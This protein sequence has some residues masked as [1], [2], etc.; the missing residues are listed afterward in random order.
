MATV[1]VTSSPTTLDTG[2]ATTRLI[3]DNRGP[4]PVTLSNGTTV[5]VFQ[6]RQVAITAGTPLTATA[7]V[8]TVV[9]VDGQPA[10]ALDADSSGHKDSSVTYSDLAPNARSGLASSPEMT[11]T[12]ASINSDRAGVRAAAVMGGS[13]AANGSQWPNGRFTSENFLNTNTRKRHTLLAA[14]GALRLVYVN[15]WGSETLTANSISVSAALETTGGAFLPV[16]FRGARK[17]VI[18]PGGMVVSDPINAPYAVGDNVWSR[19]YVS[20]I[21][22]GMNFPY[23]NVQTLQSTWGEAS[24]GAN[25]VSQS[26]KT[27]S[28]TISGAISGYAPLVIVT[29]AIGP[30]LPTVALL[31][32][33]ITSGSGESGAPSSSGGYGFMRRALGATFP[34]LDLSVPG[35]ELLGSVGYVGTDATVRRIRAALAA[36]CT[37]AVDAWGINDFNRGTPQTFAAMQTGKIA[38]WT[39]M[40]NA[41]VKVFACT[42]TP[43]STSTDT[44]ATVVNQ[45]VKATGFNSQGRIDLNNWVRD[46][47]PILAGVAAATGSN[48]TGTL[49]AG[50]TGH[51]LVGYFETADAVE[52]SR[53][54]GLWQV[55][56]IYTT[57]SLGIHPNGTG[58][59]AMAAAIATSRFTV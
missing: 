21:T 1:T 41:G 23:H 43:V 6:A 11:G 9:N 28:G 17:A 59:A 18:E 2:S 57:D 35:K 48:A 32:D 54:S 51:P 8:N 50:Q 46:G 27:L 53:D 34:T 20:D 37:H 40:Y 38:L 3:V 19:T 4:A 36:G 22:A 30:T 49:R 7:P 29:A 56:K 39:E 26:D 55:G 44:W 15:V 33:S 42:L 58:H 14:G 52:S 10:V 25:G 47:A 31:G 5:P 12:Y 24:D 16:F 45:T 13:P